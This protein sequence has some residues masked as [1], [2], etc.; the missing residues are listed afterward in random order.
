MCTQVC[1]EY[2]D[3]RSTLDQLRIVCQNLETE[4]D[5]TESDLSELNSEHQI[6]KNKYDTYKHNISA[7]IQE[8]DQKG[9]TMKTNLS[10]FNSFRNYFTL[11]FIQSQ[12]LVI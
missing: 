5:Q 2:D 4:R 12:M 8:Y 7:E 1:E 10:K 6:L 3:V 9:K 11:Y